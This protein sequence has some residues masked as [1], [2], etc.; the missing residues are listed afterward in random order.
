M[1][2]I[3]LSFVCVSLFLVSS[4]ALA[5]EAPA[6][7]QSC[8]CPDPAKKPKPVKV[9]RKRKTPTKPCSCPA[10]AQGP[11]G[12]RGPEGPAGPEG[13]SGPPGERGPDGPQGP[14]GPRGP[15]GPAGVTTP[16]NIALGVMGAA[17]F[18]EKDYAWAWGPA[19]EL[20]APLNARTE[21]TIA[22]GLAAGA[23]GADWS[24]GRERGTIFRVALTRFVKPW[25]GLTMGVSSQSIN[26]IL[27]DK[28][29]GGYLG[30][31]PGLVLRKRWSDVTLRVE[32]T[33]FVGGS[34]Y[35]SDVGDWDLSYGPSG[36]AFLS[37]N[38]H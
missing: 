15:Q 10:G 35:A 20:Q 36:G 24:P 7:Q 30:V 8:T 34:S 5:Q 12:P 14:A 16:L 29:D 33:A 18:P 2:S 9:K 32:A 27:P 22:V 4:P 23:D 19:L 37:W 26:G 21:L 17:Y 38:W 11:E 1:K 31:T 13:P 6:L 25:L 3:V 28:E